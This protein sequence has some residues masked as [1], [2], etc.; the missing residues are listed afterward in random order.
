MNFLRLL[1]VIIIF[2]FILIGCTDEIEEI[3]IQ[4]TG[5]TRDPAREAE[6]RNIL[7]AAVLDAVTPRTTLS[8]REERA[9]AEYENNR[10]ELIRLNLVL[11]NLYGEP[12]YLSE[13][14]FC[15]RGEHNLEIINMY[16]E[17]IVP[18]VY[19]LVRRF[20]EG[21]AAVYYRSALNTNKWGFINTSGEIVIR[22]VYDG[23]FAFSDGLAAVFN[24]ADAD[25]DIWECGFIDKSGEIIIPFAYYDFAPYFHGGY[26]VILQDGKC[27][28]IDR[29][30]GIVIALGEYQDISQIGEG[31]FIAADYSEGDER[32]IYGVID[33]GNNIII[34]FE[35]HHIWSNGSVLIFN[36]DGQFGVMD[37]RGEII[38][39]AVH[40]F[41]LWH[42]FYDSEFGFVPRYDKYAM[43]DRNGEFINDLIF[44]SVRG[45]SD[46]LARATIGTET[47]FI[48]E[49]GDIVLSVADIP[50]TINF[51]ISDFHNGVAIVRRN[52]TNHYPATGH[53]G[54]IDK[55]GM[56]VLPCVY[57]DI[58]ILGDRFIAVQRYEDG[59]WD[60]YKIEEIN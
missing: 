25:N 16:G 47:H 49:A 12:E 26:A 54:L 18:P 23:A 41:I 3:D 10:S 46:G 1:I 45:L 15:V 40:D 2:A 48:D 27:G 13:G 50:I 34:P 28:V 52:A 55:S 43:I 11:E 53:L 29:A 8:H 35:Y 58:R 9:I 22:P 60:V 24:L 30:G 5:V 20:S 4:P 17:S 33:A 7:E 21:L 51:H 44:D 31:L 59:T 6:L 39:P 56:I 57:E 42:S 37:T 38:I 19:N 32:W 14:L 36:Q